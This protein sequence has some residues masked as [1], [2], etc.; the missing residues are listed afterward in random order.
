MHATLSA[1]MVPLYTLHSCFHQNAER[2]DETGVALGGWIRYT[3]YDPEQRPHGC[4]FGDSFGE[5]HEPLTR[6]GADAV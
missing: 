4:G 5:L 3:M 2:A 6:R 1:L